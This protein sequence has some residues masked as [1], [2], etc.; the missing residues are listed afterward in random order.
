MVIHVDEDPTTT[1]FGGR[2]LQTSTRKFKVLERV[3]HDGTSF[4]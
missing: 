1:G 2:H 4:V 3:G